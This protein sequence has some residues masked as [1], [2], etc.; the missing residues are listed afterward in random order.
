LLQDGRV[1]LTGW[2]GQ[3]GLALLLYDATHKT[4]GHDGATF[5]PGAGKPVAGSIAVRLLD[6]RVL[7]V[8]PDG[9]AELFTP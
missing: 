3:P 8:Q 6:G 9:T 5:G 4:F 1:L 7:I 2:S